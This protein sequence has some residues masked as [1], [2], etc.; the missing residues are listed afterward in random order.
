MKIAIFDLIDLQLR[1]KIGM[2]EKQEN[3]EIGTLFI[4]QKF[5]FRTFF[6]LQNPNKLTWDKK[7]GCYGPFI[8]IHFYIK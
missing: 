8:V 5:G 7:L 3:A 2:S 6:D 4:S 1:S